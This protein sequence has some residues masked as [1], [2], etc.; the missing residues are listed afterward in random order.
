MGRGVEVAGANRTGDRKTP[1][2][3][4]L[5]TLDVAV[6]R[7]ADDLLPAHPANAHRLVADAERVNPCVARVSPE[8]RAWRETR[9]GRTCTDHEHGAG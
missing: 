6:H 4:D 2:D 1:M 5:D 3:A 8:T 7:T 9:R